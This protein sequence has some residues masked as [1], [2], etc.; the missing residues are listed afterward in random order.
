MSEFKVYVGVYMCVSKRE[1]ERQYLE[2]AAS[3]LPSVSLKLNALRLAMDTDLHSCVPQQETDLP[4]NKPH[5]AH[6]PLSLN[7]FVVY[8][9][10]V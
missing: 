4:G 9:S 7:F 10:L 2:T 1:K 8:E 3:L 6:R 5:F